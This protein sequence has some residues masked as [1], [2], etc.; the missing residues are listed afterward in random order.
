MK[1]CAISDLHGW[2]PEINSCELLLISGDI[3]PLDIQRNYVN[4]AN[5]FYTEFT[6]WIGKLPCDKV[7]FIA[8]N[9]DFYLSRVLDFPIKEWTKGK[10]EYLQDSLYKYLDST[11]KEWNIY[12]TPWTHKFGN[13]AF[14]LDDKSLINM[15]QKMPSN[16]D[17]LLTHDTP[18]YKE[19]GVLPPSKWSLEEVDV[20][21]TPL[22]KFIEEK[23]PK[24]VFCGHLHTCKSKYEKINKSEVYN[25]SIL[26][27]DYQK[28]YTPLYLEI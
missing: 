5:W 17:I 27:N 20:G 25:V 16:I 19:L 7:L 3:I 22:I 13:W 6:D 18:R 8:G 28:T 4:S 23:Q 21:N 10:C 12:G 14:M 15:Y 9:H 1:I 2:L 11:G 24:Y 26:N